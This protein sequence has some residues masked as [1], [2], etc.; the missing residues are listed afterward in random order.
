[1]PRNI[2]FALTTDQIRNRTKTVTR[3]LGWKNLKRG[4]ILNACVK[5]MGL[6]PGE[7][8]ERLGQIRVVD[9]RQEP[10][11][12]IMQDCEYGKSEAEKEGFPDLDGKQFAEMFCD[13]MRPVNGCVTEVTRIEFEYVELASDC[14]DFKFIEINPRRKARGIEAARVEVDGEWMWMSKY[15]IEANMRDFGQHPELLKALESYK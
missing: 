3:R 7:K 6:K 5:C 12:A 14:P 10:L 15:D 2:S 1:M 11:V 13:H 4:D 9:V 8:I